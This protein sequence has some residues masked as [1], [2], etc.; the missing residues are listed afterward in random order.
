MSTIIKKYG[1]ALERGLL[2]EF[3]PGILKG[4]LVE[5]FK[6]RKLNVAK[7]TSW[8]ENNYNL[9]GALDLKE[10]KQ[11][12]NLASRVGSLDWLNADWAIRAIKDD[13][14]A[15]ASLL[16]GWKKGHNW[17][18]RQVELVKENITDAGAKR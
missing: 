6:I 11:F 16:L 12:K 4:A 18:A 15:V 13:F 10:Q 17:L 9:W 8:V 2:G 3:A 1:Q 5:L 14:P 7:A